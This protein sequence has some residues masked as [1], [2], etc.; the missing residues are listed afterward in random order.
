MTELVALPGDFL[1]Y[2]E[3]RL[4]KLLSKFLGG[5]FLALADFA[6]INDDIVFVSAAVDLNGAEREFVEGH[7]RTTGTPAF[8]RFS[9]T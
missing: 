8:R 9:S 2:R 4:D 1:V 7:T 3:R 6:A 5:L